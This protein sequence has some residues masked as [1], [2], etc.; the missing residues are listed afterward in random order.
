[1]VG[2]RFLKIVFDNAL[3]FNVDEIYVTIFNKTQDQERLI[4]LLEDWG[5]TYHGIK[6]S[7]S[8]NEL[9]YVREF[10]P[11]ANVSDPCLTYPYFS[12][13]QRKFIVPI[14][15]QYHTEL[16]PDS[17][18]RTESPQDYVESRP[19]RN[20]ISKVYIS[21]SIERDLRPGDI[22][23]FYRTKYKGHA[24]YTS[25]A[26]TIGVVQS[27]VTNIPNLQHFIQLCRKR[28]VFS[29]KE[30]GDHWNYNPRNRP[31]I[32][33]FL[34]VHS[35]PK[36]LNL[37]ALLDL[38]IIGQAPRGFEQ[39]SDKAFDKLMEESNGNQRLIIN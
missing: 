18:L 25:V 10:T 20:A 27:I 22:I 21:R 29:D 35:F 37:K 1:M 15:P 12:G 30:L 32:V 3:R 17:I 14:Y 5:F 4:N 2:E 19:N 24:Y 34:Y 36:R 13:Q 39:L 16:F 8:G 33:N 11:S 28:S 31:F 6:H 7:S 9:V 26:T 23:V 38:Q